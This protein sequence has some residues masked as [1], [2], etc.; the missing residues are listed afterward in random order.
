LSIG[1]K[2]FWNY[3]AFVSF[4]S[5]FYSYSYSYSIFYY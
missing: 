4:E 3:F 5:N 1:Y 2:L